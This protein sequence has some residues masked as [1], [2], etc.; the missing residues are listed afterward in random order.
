MNLSGSANASGIPGFM[1]QFPDTPNEPLPQETARFQEWLVAK[2]PQ[3]DFTDFARNPEKVEEE[4][5]IRVFVD[6]RYE[7]SQKS[8]HR[9]SKDE[10][11]VREKLTDADG[12]PI[13]N[14][15]WK[16]I[17]QWEESAGHQMI[18]T[19]SRG[20]NNE[21]GTVN[22]PGLHTHSWSGEYSSTEQRSVATDLDGVMTETA[23]RQVGGLQISDEQSGVERSRKPPLP[24]WPS[25]SR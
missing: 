9:S 1:L 3:S 24:P 21:K 13:H 19:H 20:R 25:L 11:R 5:A 14:G 23:P 12:F 4:H 16:V 17:R 2:Q 6:Y 8:H 7:T 15:E 10:D 22:S 18:I